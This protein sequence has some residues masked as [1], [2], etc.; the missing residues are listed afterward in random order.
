MHDERRI[1]ITRKRIDNRDYEALFT[2]GGCYHFALRLHERFE[3]QIRGVREGHDRNRFSHVWCQM[4]GTCKGVD[5]QGVY[6]EVLLAR[7]ANGGNL[8]SVFNVPVDEVREMIR[9]KQYTIE[10]DAEIRKLADW[11]FDNHERFEAAK[12]RDENQYNQFLKDIGGE[13]DGGAGINSK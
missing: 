3:Y 11:I 1:A 4:P 9:S 8:A 10:L 13:C 2:G 12:P 7:V 5:I 6:P